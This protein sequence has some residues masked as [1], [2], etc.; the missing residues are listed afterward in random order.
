MHQHLLDPARNYL[1]TPQRNNMCAMLPSHPE[2]CQL[3]KVLYDSAVA[4]Y[5]NEEDLS[6]GIE[7]LARRR[8]FTTCSWDVKYNFKGSH[9]C[10]GS[11]SELAPERKLLFAIIYSRIS[12]NG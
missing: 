7:I 8:V 2:C 6:G 9:V 11:H 12:Q 1:N 4:M 3:Y 5:R 10:E